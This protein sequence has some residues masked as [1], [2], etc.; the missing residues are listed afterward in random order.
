MAP[1]PGGEGY[2]RLS[3]EL[4][5]GRYDRATDLWSVGVVAYVLLY[6]IPPFNGNSEAA[7]REAIRTNQ[8][9]FKGN[10]WADKG[11]GAVDF[12]RGLL[13]KDPRRRLTAREALAHPWLRDKITF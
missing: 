1:A 13:R 5:G 7:V 2:L 9:H 3:P 6:G 8:P 4:L 11:D 12:V 10:G